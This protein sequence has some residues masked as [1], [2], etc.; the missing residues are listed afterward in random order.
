MATAFDR[1]EKDPFFYAAEEVQ[2]S[3]DRY[4][5]FL[6]SLLVVFLEVSL[7]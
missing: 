7:Y 2:E 3:T 5:F 4:R 6:L 1:W